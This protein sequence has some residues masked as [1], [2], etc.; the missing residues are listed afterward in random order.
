M[1]LARKVV[2]ADAHAY[3]FSLWMPFPEWFAILKSMQGEV[4]NS[5]VDLGVELPIRWAIFEVE[6]F[7][8]TICEHGLSF[9][10]ALAKNALPNFNG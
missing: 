8:F 7:C 10:M 1:E 2:A 3:G 5:K 9:K 6:P 4:P